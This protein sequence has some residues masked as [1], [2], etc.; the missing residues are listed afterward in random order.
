MAEGGKEMNNP[1][2]EKEELAALKPTVGSKS[3]F[4]L[5]KYKATDR[6]SLPI[7]KTSSHAQYNP[8]L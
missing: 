3:F 6:S 7:K 4:S 5:K 1:Q 2:G 8:K